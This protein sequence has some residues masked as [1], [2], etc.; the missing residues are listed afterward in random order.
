MQTIIL[1]QKLK[2]ALPNWVFQA[3]G[4]DGAVACYPPTH[5]GPVS[6][7]FRQLNSIAIISSATGNF[8]V[9][10]LLRETLLEI[11]GKQETK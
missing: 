5:I 1:I 9:V 4:N 7:S 3:Y 8:Y 2:A 11:C 10:S 6:E